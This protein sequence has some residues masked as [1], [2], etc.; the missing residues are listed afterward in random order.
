MNGKHLYI[1]S[2]FLT[3]AFVTP[4]AM[5]AAPAPQ[6]AGVQ[7]R[8]YDSGHKD[9]HNWDD[10]ENHAW[11]STFRK[12]TGSPMNSGSR[13]RTKNR[14]TGIGVMITKTMAMTIQTNT[15]TAQ[16][17]GDSKVRISVE[18]T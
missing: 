4:V 5:M 3:A 9:Y 6:R 14:N 7:V 8:V 15:T 18:G 10:N 2:L 17:I 12:T 16:T 13:K 11:G 1:A